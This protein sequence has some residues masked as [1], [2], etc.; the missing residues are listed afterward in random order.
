MEFFDL[1]N[2]NVYQLK[3]LSKNKTCFCKN[4]EELITEILNNQFSD[5]DLYKY[6]NDNDLLKVD[7]IEELFNKNNINSLYS[8][9]DYFSFNDQNDYFLIYINLLID[10]LN[11][12]SLLAQNYTETFNYLISYN[13]F[14][15]QMINIFNFY[16]EDSYKIFELLNKII[17]TNDY[18]IL[19]KILQSDCL[20]EQKINKI[21]QLFISFVLLKQNK[22]ID[23]LNLLK[24]FE[25]NG[26]FFKK[27]HMFFNPTEVSIFQSVRCKDVKS[28]ISII[29]EECFNLFEF[30]DIDC[31]LLDNLF[32]EMYR[33]NIKTPY[34]NL[35]I[36]RKQEVVKFYYKFFENSEEFVGFIDEF[37]SGELNL[38]KY[39]IVESSLNK[40]VNQEFNNC[41]YDKDKLLNINEDS[42]IYGLYGNFGCILLK[43]YYNNHKIINKIDIKNDI[44]SE[45][46]LTIV[47]SYCIDNK[48]Q[49]KFIINTFYKAK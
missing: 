4:I 39:N 42:K 14:N 33:D 3:I 27:N 6:I 25:F 26:V 38:S 48:Y 30:E 43:E 46:F 24:T 7:L 8:K 44:N 29:K 17:D 31:V 1:L 19:L 2:E 9:V 22:F 12:N 11:D 5:I 32:S 20:Y 23:K 10:C 16:N 21:Y 37:N 49:F 13:I 45:I 18:E 35:D 41:I 47:K 36:N 15:P 40:Y 28:P 34:I